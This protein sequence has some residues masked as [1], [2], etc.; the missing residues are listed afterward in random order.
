MT[1]SL[2][3]L[4]AGK[5][6]ATLHH[7]HSHRHKL[8]SYKTLRLLRESSS[9]S[10][11]ASDHCLARTH[12]PRFRDQ[13]KA[14]RS[15][16]C[17]ERAEDSTFEEEEEKE[18]LKVEADERLE[19]KGDEK[20]D[21]FKV[22]YKEE[23]EEEKFFNYGEPL[24]WDKTYAKESEPLEWYQSYGDM[25][26]LVRRYIPLSSRILMAGC[27]NAGLFLDFLCFV[28]KFLWIGDY[29]YF[30]KSRLCL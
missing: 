10:S 2:S 17:S 9:F 21:K 5:L 23:E 28:F 4:R 26:P 1:L 11:S 19:G 16:F 29:A 6:M 8:L 24:F 7:S 18:E 13:K 15:Y 22:N 30:G 12:A 27:G 14:K 25:A 3:L 20:E